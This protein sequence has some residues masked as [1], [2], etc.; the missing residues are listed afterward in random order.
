MHL[1]YIDG[2]SHDRRSPEMSDFLML[3]IVLMIFIILLIH[4]CRKKMDVVDIL[5]THIEQ[6]AMNQSCQCARCPHRNGT[7]DYPRSPRPQQQ[8][9]PVPP[10]YP[11]EQH[12]LLPRNGH[13]EAELRMSTP[14]LLPS[15][16]S[17]QPDLPTTPPPRYEDIFS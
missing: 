10:P 11:L 1:K 9:H 7:D 14:D 17:L 2:I 16:P 5:D 4:F 12:P 3:F 6:P 15:A 8:Q 13:D